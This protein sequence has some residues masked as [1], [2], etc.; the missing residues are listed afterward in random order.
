MVPVS[1]HLMDTESGFAPWDLSK[2]H[3]L[4]SSP[5]VCSSFVFM[6]LGSKD[7]ENFIRK[8][9]WSLELYRLLTHKWPVRIQTQTLTIHSNVTLTCKYISGILDLYLGLPI[10]IYFYQCMNIKEIYAKGCVCI[11]ASATACIAK[12]Q[13]KHW[14][15]CRRS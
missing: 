8:S 12:E 9:C 11:L 10:H 14:T 3:I 2:A 13:R 4:V 1:K 7:E 5:A 15:N 6:I